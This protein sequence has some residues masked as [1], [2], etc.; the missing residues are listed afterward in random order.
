MQPCGALDGK[1]LRR[2]PVEKEPTRAAGGEEREHASPTY[3]RQIEYVRGYTQ[4]TAAL[5]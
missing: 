3:T 2:T 4:H 5:L 1:C